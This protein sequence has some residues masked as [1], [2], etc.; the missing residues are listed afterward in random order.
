MHLL[1][2]ISNKAM[3]I[4]TFPSG[5]LVDS[6]L[7]ASLKVR[8][9]EGLHSHKN[10][11]ELNICSPFLK[12]FYYQTLSYFPCLS[13]LSPFL[14]FQASFLGLNS[15]L[16]D[17]LHLFMQFSTVLILKLIFRFSKSKPRTTA[18]WSY[19]SEPLQGYGSRGTTKIDVPSDMN[20]IISR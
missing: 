11:L 10:K 5:I 15:T 8:E 2:P 13:P 17:Y 20:Y 16:P 14:S 12:L 4:K 7:D 19:F 6:V 9:D 18:L 1:Y 3:K